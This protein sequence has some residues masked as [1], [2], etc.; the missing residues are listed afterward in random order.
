MD[1]VYST[2]I[3]ITNFI[4]CGGVI[5]ITLPLPLLEVIPTDLL[6]LHIP[7]RVELGLDECFKH[8]PLSY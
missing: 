1:V 2:Y 4:Y 7:N 8:F 3:L 5:L 6:V